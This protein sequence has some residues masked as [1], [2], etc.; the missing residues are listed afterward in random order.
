MIDI[1]IAGV[2]KSS[3]IDAYGIMAF[4]LDRDITGSLG[5]L[6]MKDAKRDRSNSH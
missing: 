6:S 2:A 5:S 4:K 1:H 3:L